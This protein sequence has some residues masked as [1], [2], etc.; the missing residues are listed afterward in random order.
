MNLE[1]LRDYCLAKKGVTESFPFGEEAL[2]FKVA[3]K[4]FCLAN[5]I[6]PY[7]INLKCDPE[8]AAELCEHYEAVTPGYHM[9]KKH[10]NTVDLGGNVP[11]SEILGW[12][13]HSYDLVVKSLSKKKR[14]CLE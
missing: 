10:W 4:I 14:A 7:S 9:N 13:D 5:M 11:D 1:K 2:V 6:P 12:I 8:Y 3:D